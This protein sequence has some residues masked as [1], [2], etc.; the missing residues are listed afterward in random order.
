MIPTPKQLLALWETVRTSFWFVPSL[1]AAAAVALALVM[2]QVDRL[3]TDD[4]I[5]PGSWIHGGGP[6]GARAVLSTAAGSMITV[7]GVVFS[8][9]IVA[10]TLASAQFGSRLLRTFMRD[11]GNQVVL[12]TFIATFVYCL[13]VLPTVGE[14]DGRAFVPHL[15]I[16]VA[17]GLALA[18]LGVLIFF[19]HHVARSIQAETV[20]A[21]VADDLDDVIEHLFP[22][23]I[24][25]DP[26]DGDAGLPPDFA[27][28]ARPV[29]SRRDGY[30]L[31][32][33]DDALMALA[34]AH[35][36]LLRIERRPGHFVVAGDPLAL[37]AAPAGRI[38]DGLADAIRR[39]FVLD[40]RRSLPQD[41]EFGL[42]QL[43]EL[44]LRGLSPGINDPFLAITC[45]DRL[46][47][48]LCRLAR[49]SMPSPHRHDATGRLRVVAPAES[50]D[51]LL[52]CAL[53]PIRRYGREH[54][55]V[56]IRLLGTIAAIAGDTRDERRRRLLRDH[57]DAVLDAGLA[58]LTDERDRQAV[59]AKHEAVTAV[60][61][62]QARPDDARP[63]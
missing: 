53:D 48:A 25:R 11:L 18:S 31:V 42:T 7:A 62:D 47:Q 24:G 40:V 59:R 2:V 19:I 60:L 63:A 13:L 4:R 51:R 54:P 49:R 22:E 1:M 30:V 8:I 12:G 21:A 39:T 6:E 58:A 50:F 33:D 16:T 35:D 44:A 52:A 57:A 15:S 34:E 28:S 61:A 46:G 3:A 14:T 36:L 29:A 37:A 9:T 5:Q 26:P 45:I 20:I 38:D 17:L 10:L 56:M 32:I 27:R 43:V 55:S 41:A 23:E